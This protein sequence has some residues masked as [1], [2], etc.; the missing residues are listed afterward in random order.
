MAASITMTASECA[1][2]M[3]KAGIKCTVNHV[4]DGIACGAYPFGRLCGG[5]DARRCVE[6]FRVDFESWLKAKTPN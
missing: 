2:A 6:I 4:V 1:K 3:R 5:S